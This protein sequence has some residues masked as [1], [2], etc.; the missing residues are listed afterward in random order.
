[1]IKANAPASLH[2]AF[3]VSSLTDNGAGDYTLS[4]ARAFN[5]TAYAVVM[6]CTGVASQWVHQGTDDTVVPTATT[7]RVFTLNV[8]GALT[9]QDPTTVM[10]VGEL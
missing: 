4:F 10:V 9:Y 8:G 1:V 2:S 7:C 3:N 6:M 5:A